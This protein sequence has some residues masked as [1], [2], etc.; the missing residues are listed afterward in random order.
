MRLGVRDKLFAGFG[1]VLLLT[2]IVGYIGWRNTNEYVAEF[3][4]MHDDRLLP[5]VQL[6]GVQ[7]GLYELRL[8]AAGVAY[9]LADEPTRARIRTAD[10]RWLKQIDDNI[11]AFRTTDLNAST[12]IG[13]EG[14]RGSYGHPADQV[15]RGGVPCRFLSRCRRC[16][17]RTLSGVGFSS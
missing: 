15:V 4:T 5:A 13:S 3:R 2:A 6:S 10:Q 9:A 12:K 8:G 17:R 7:Q 11:K 16:P 1:A 14:G